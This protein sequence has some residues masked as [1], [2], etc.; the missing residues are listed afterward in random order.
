MVGDD[1]ETICEG[2]GTMNKRIGTWAVAFIMVALLAASVALAGSLASRSYRMLGEVTAKFPAKPSPFSKSEYRIFEVPGPGVLKITVYYDHAPWDGYN[3]NWHFHGVPESGPVPPINAYNG[4]LQDILPHTSLLASYVKPRPK[5][6]MQPVTYALYYVVDKGRA[7]FEIPPLHDNYNQFA[8]LAVARFFF[9]PGLPVEGETFPDDA[10]VPPPPPENTAPPSSTLAPG[11]GPVLTVDEG[12]VWHGTWTR[13][14][15]T[16]IFDATWRGPNGGVA[17]DVI[18]IVS[19]VGNTVTFKRT[20]NHGTYTGT[21][22]PDGTSVAGTAS[23]YPPG[24]KWSGSAAKPPVG[25]ALAAE[26]L[27]EWKVWSGGLVGAGDENHAFYT[28]TLVI[29]RG[30]G[31]LQA[32]IRFDSSGRWETLRNVTYEGGALEFDRSVPSPRGQ[33]VQHYSA[34]VS[35]G[36]LRGTFSTDQK[37]TQRWWG[38]Q[39]R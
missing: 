33:A 8:L 32:R 10:S 39:N 15:G 7:L 12:G 23:W 37:A 1:Q 25:P 16:G 18:E 3:D 27:G 17:S 29:E 38:A 28:A 21:M 22:S 13:R 26:V 6:F 9:S 35:G 4:A 24:W 30:S 19:V 2:S 5:V 31:G 14:P 11:L 20:G 34:P 36:R